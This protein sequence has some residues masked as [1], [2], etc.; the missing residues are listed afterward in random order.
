M[1]A[2][3]RVGGRHAKRVFSTQKKLY[4]TVFHQKTTVWSSLGRISVEILMA[5]FVAVSFSYGGDAAAFILSS[6]V[7][8]F[9]V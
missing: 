3:R 9:I 8:L 7:S 1:L 2:T 5:R 6:F 4:F